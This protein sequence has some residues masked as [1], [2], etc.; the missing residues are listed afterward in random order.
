MFELTDGRT[1]GRVRI[2]S[3][4][5]Y[6]AFG[7]MGDNYR[8]FGATGNNY[9][10][11][12]VGIAWNFFL[13]VCAHLWGI[14]VWLGANTEASSYIVYLFFIFTRMPLDVMSGIGMHAI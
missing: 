3:M 14:Y 12:G 13:I 6:R 1:D 11:I 7:T 5:P 2:I 8:A 9:S 10:C 4:S